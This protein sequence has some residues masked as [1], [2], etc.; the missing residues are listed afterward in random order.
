MSNE[1]T[2]DAARE[3]C[4]K[5]GRQLA[6]SGRWTPGTNDG[7]CWSPVMQVCDGASVLPIGRSDDD[8]SDRG[9]A[10]STARPS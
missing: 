10:T 6:T 9:G 4:P 5:C 1:K 2:S 3:R 7:R 8:D